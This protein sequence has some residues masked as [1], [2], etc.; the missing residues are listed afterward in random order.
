MFIKLLKK[1][2][3]VLL[4]MNFLA[5]AAL[6]PPATPSAADVE[7]EEQV[8]YSFFL[9]NSSSG[10]AALILEETSSNI[11]EMTPQEMREQI[12]D[13]FKS[14]SKDTVD[15]YLARNEQSSPL[16]PTMDLD[17]EYILITRD[18]LSEITS[19]PN[20]GEILT[21]RY[22]GSYGYT[23]FSRVGFNNTL[24]QAVVYV[25]G[26]AGPMMGSGFY[27]LMEKKDGEWRIMEQVMVWI[28]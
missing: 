11:S 5:C 3:I 25:G 9:D 2:S 19:Q 21:E 13:S 6:V 16:S 26:M 7:K 27:Y 17:V 14:V 23:I 1:V 20:W 22:P 12:K 8:I 10:G 4:A 28:S 15:S 24:D 18:Q